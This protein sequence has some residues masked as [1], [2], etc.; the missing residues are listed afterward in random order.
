[1]LRPI[2]PGPLFIGILLG[3]FILAV[4]SLAEKPTRQKAEQDLV[5]LSHKL[6]QAYLVSEKVPNSY[7]KEQ[8]IHQALSEAQNHAQ[9]VSALIVSIIIASLIKPKKIRAHRFL[10]QSP[11]LIRSKMA[12]ENRWPKLNSN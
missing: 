4:G 1:M 12:R 2:F 10:K 9:I 5:I 6:A 3:F 11:W 7:L 8:I